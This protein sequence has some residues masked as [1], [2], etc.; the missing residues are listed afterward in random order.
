MQ[1]YKVIL[2]WESIYDVTDIA[3]YIEVEFC[4]ERA[5]RFQNDMQEQLKDLGRFGNAFS[6]THIYYRNYSIYKKPFLPSIVFYIIK[7]AEKEIHVLRVLREE[8]DW[9]KILTEQEEYTYP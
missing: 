3:Y 5:D 8:C 4:K 6:K 7:E 2:T 9:E 1:E